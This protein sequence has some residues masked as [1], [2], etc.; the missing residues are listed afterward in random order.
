MVVRLGH[1]LFA[2]RILLAADV[3]YAD[4]SE[5]TE[6]KIEEDH[7]AVVNNFFCGTPVKQDE[8][9]RSPKRQTSKNGKS[10]KSKSIVK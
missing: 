9:K 5:R 4:E 7:F 8:L 6:H 10:Q 2:D 1:I 3:G